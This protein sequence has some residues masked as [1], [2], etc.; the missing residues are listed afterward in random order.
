GEGMVIEDVDG[1]RYL[2]FTSGIAVASTGHCHPAVVEAAVR[3]TRNLIHMSGTDFYYR[4]EVLLA[5]KLT[6]ITPGAFSKKVFFT[7]SGTEA[8]EA[9]MKLARY[10]TRRPLFLAFSGGFHGRTMG[11]LSLT[12]SKAVHRKGFSPLV[13]GVTHVPYAYCYRC[14]YGLKPESCNL[15]CV[16]WIEEELF[17]TQV[18]PEEV[19]ALFV[20]PIQGEGGYVV[21]PPGFLPRLRELTA[22]YG[23]LLAVDEI[24]TGM[25]RTGRMFACD[26]EGVVPEILMIAKGIASGFP[27]GAMVSAASV[28]TWVRGSHANT[29]GGNPVACEAALATIRLLEEGLVENAAVQGEYLLSRLREMKALYP[30]I[31][32]VRGKGLMVGVEFVLDSETRAPAHSYR[33]RVVQAC[34]RKGLL[35]LGCGENV[36]RFIPPLIVSREEIDT[37]L[38]IFQEGVGEVAGTM[39]PS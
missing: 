3:Q 19:A 38:A 26:H 18:P 34:F 9:A 35:L 21:P 6:A 16:A 17:R 29:F 1:N 15:Y 39:I 37:A 11:A 4:P 33:E 5:E 32:D 31:G 24:Q 10:H 13:P 25:G 12:A 23:I 28:T 27:L 36:I 22:K 8:T 30:V 14:A 20:E 2:D 7:N